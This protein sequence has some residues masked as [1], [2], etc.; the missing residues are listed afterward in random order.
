[1]DRTDVAIPQH[2]LCTKIR[3][4]VW[5]EVKVMTLVNIKNGQI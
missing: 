3:N 2:L 5:K 1:M 4:A